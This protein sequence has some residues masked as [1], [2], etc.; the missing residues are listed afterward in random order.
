MRAER[1][2]AATDSGTAESCS[3]GP[4]AARMVLGAHL[5]RLREARSLTREAAGVRIRASESKMSRLEMGRT[6][7]KSRDLADL[8]RLY[9]VLDEAEEA[10][11][12]DLAKESNTRGWWQRF[13]DLVPPWYE[14]CLGLEQV[15]DVI[16]SYAVQTVPDL[17][18]TADYARAELT[19]R[20]DN[21]RDQQIDRRLELRMRRQQILHRPEPVQLW[22]II[23]EGALRRPIGGAAVMRAQIEHLIDLAQL[24]NVRIQAL[25]FASGGHVALGGPITILRLPALELPDVVFLEQLDGA[26]YPDR[27]ADVLRYRQ[28]MDKLGTDAEQP[29]DT[30]TM[31]RGIVKDFDRH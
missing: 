28:I 16:R 31:L 19:L 9:E 24:P 8:F 26:R 18:Q 30:V 1:S 7:F 27:P 29:A 5:R 22:E 6:G 4:T 13:G 20:H 25:P 21:E 10:M 23:D 14:S 3:A 17:L 2:V 12:W 15:A 11:L